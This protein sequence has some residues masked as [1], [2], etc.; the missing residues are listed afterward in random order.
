MQQTDLEPPR[1]FIGFHGAIMDDPATVVITEGVRRDCSSHVLVG[2]C[3]GVESANH[4]L[5]FAIGGK[6]LVLF[7]FIDLL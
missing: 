2:S 5:L 4:F 3:E 7:Y 6:V 1:A